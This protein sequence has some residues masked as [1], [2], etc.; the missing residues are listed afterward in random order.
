VVAVPPVNQVPVMSSGGVLAAPLR[1][2]SVMSPV[3]P[4]TLPEAP[5]WAPA[6]L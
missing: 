2:P 3:A 6:L 5:A 1:A 4:T